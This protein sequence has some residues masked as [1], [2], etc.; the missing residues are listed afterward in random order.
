MEFRSCYPGWSAMVWSRLT[1]TSAS[2]FKWS[3]CL[4]SP[5]AGIIGGCYH[6]WLM[7]ICLVKMRFCHVGQ[8]GLELL[9]SSD[10]PALASQSAGITGVSHCA[11]PVYIASYHYW[12]KI[13]ILGT[14]AYKKN[15]NIII[16][17]IFYISIYKTNLFFPGTS[18]QNL[19][20]KSSFWL[21]ISI[22]LFG[23]A[24]NYSKTT[25][26]TICISK[27]NTLLWRHVC[28]LVQ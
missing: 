21:I 17:F 3:S 10:L 6:T 5:D 9:T 1:T 18:Y 13:I 20:R 15:H 22:C 28:A 11:R 24:V 2:R 23:F 7:F 25:F 12:L 27:W 19:F 26:N 4:A 16:L 8:A 14:R